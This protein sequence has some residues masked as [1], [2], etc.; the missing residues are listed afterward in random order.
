MV[1]V[2]LAHAHN[3]QLQLSSVFCFTIDSNVHQYLPTGKNGHNN[4]SAHHLL[5]KLNENG[6][7]PKNYPKY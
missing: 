5:K 3:H 6:I 2:L 1:L 4:L 7:K